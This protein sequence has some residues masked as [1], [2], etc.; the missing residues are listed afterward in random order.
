MAA[1][2]GGVDA[3]AFTGGAGERSPE[4]R[5][6]AVEGLEFLGLAIDSA[7]NRAASGDANISAPRA[8]V[9]TLVLAARED[10]EISRQ[11]RS[12]LAP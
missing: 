4:L 6:L 11:V 10:L 1:A 2:L 3:V 7:D 8:S 12:V 5:E 9:A